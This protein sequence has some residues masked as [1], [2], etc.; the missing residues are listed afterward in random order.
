MPSLK[1]KIIGLFVVGDDVSIRRTI[2]RS[3]SGL[4][5]GTTITEAWMT[6]KINAVDV[7]PGLFQ[8]II[9]TTDVP[10]TG[11]IENNGTGDVDIVVR[12]DLLPADTVA[13]GAVLIRQFDI[14]VLTNGG[15]IYT[16]ERGEIKA[17]EQVTLD[18]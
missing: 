14:Q 5:A 18:I 2:D 17:V 4:T 3:V 13:I 16:P 7:D 6:C 15:Q 1:S 8:K 10:G 11:Q 9:T 12:F